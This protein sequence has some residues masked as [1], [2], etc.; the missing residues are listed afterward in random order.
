MTTM[1]F[2]RS[3]CCL[4]LLVLKCDGFSTSSLLRSCSSSSQLGVSNFLENLFAAASTTPL[5]LR[6]TT[7]K[8]L[9][10]D[11]VT[12]QNCFTTEE[13]VQAFV[14][15]CAEN[16]IYEDTFASKDPYVG[17]EQVLQHLTSKALARS[18]GSQVRI[19]KISDG[20]KACGF[21]WTWVEGDQEGLRGTTFCELD[22]QTKIAYVR[23]IPEPLNKPGD[24]TLELLKAVTKDAQ[25]KPPP[26]YEQKT[27]TKANEVAKYLFCDV[28]GGDI[29]ES[30]RLFSDDILYRDFNYEKLLSGKAEVRKFIE[31]FSFPGIIFQPDKFDD[32]QLSTCF[33]WEVCLEGVENTVKGISFYELDESTRL[34]KY[35]R[36]VPESVIKPA[37]LGSLARWLRPGLGVFQGVPTGSRPDGM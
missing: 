14:D 20:D 19:D 22:D 18:D 4:I 34:I 12:E 28:Q 29:E 21:A 17:K 2:I 10:Q 35:V 5:S 37:P 27:P 30:M 32:G 36:D 7:A 3:F 24:A 33:T 15:A 8:D 9:V 16:V 26:V 25:F 13:G 23:E 31:D 11:L 6:T 1:N